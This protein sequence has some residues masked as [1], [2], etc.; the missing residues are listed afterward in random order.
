MVV[1]LTATISFGAP[2]SYEEDV[3][4]V[5]IDVQDNL[6]VDYYTVNQNFDLEQDVYAYQVSDVDLRFVP[7]VILE[8]KVLG[9][10]PL[11]EFLP[12][13]YKKTCLTPH[14]YHSVPI[15]VQSNSSGGLSGRQR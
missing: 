1:L 4:I 12:D 15:T 6:A 5:M 9:L 2:Q 14:I 13:K 8:S 11:N 10:Q 3:G 7:K